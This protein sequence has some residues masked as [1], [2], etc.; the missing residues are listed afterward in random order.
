ML[1]RAFG[2][3]GLPFDEPVDPRAVLTASRRFELSA[4]IA[5]RQGQVRLAGEL[6]VEAAGMFQRDRL[7]ATALGMRLLGLAREVAEVA[8]PLQIPL[9][10]LKFVALDGA[11]LPVVGG[12]AA[13]D[14]DVLVPASRARDLQN[15]LTGRGF[16]PSGHPASEHQLPGL[17]HP[18]GGAVEV[19]RLMLGV[20]L[21]GNASATVEGLAKRGLLRPLDGLPGNCAVPALEAQAAHVLVHGVG[22]HGYWPASYSLFKMVGDLI[23]LGFA[24]PEPA[25]GLARRAYGWIA[26]DLS[27]GE[28]EAV[29]RLCDSLSAGGDP[30]DWDP[31]A[32]ESVLLRHILAGRLDPGYAT[33]LRLGLFRAQPTDHS[34]AGKLARSVLGALF[35]TRRQIDSIYGQPRHP[36]GYW[37]RRLS[38]P[39]DLLWRLGTY[40]ARALR[41]R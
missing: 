28:T 34:P 37:V 18:A 14:V 40:G 12:R 16:R 39:F 5:S 8:A 30:L 11:G 26:R 15:A 25:P 7:G 32:G 10:F 17:E 29:W 3:P 24:G 27:S 4:R 41:V 36:L 33:S 21:D 13:A 23:D 22:Q 19:H 20:R 38:R 6:G 9:V 2:P 31:L 35:L 1:M